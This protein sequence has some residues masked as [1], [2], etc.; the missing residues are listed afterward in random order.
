MGTEYLPVE[1]SADG[2]QYHKMFSDIERPVILAVRNT[3]KSGLFKVETEEK[4][5]LILQLHTELCRIFNLPTIPIEF[6]DGF[7]GAGRFLIGEKKLILDKPSLVTFLH[8]FCHY[9]STELKQTNSEEV[10]RGWSISLFY[11]ATPNICKSSIRKG[12]I[13]HQR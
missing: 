4:K 13:I 10:A 1:S 11:L 5:K 6:E 12:L 3:I 2:L 9:K 7:L 8:E